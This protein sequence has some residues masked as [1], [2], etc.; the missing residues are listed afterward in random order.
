M[1]IR[2]WSWRRRDED[3][4]IQLF[5]RPVTTAI[6]DD[7]EQ[8]LRAREAEAKFDHVWIF[9]ARTLSTASTATMRDVRCI[10]DGTKVPRT[11]HIDMRTSGWRGHMGQGP[12]RLRRNLAGTPSAVRMSRPTMPR[13]QAFHELKSG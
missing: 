9:E 3:C 6:L 10:P 13:I 7:S 1:R 2:S 11:G 12:C 5:W 8:Y 4:C